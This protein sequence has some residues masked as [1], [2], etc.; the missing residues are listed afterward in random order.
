MISVCTTVNK[1][2][3]ESVAKSNFELFSKYW[4]NDIKLYVY[5]EDFEENNFS[6]VIFLKLFKESSDCLDFINRNKNRVFVPK[7]K[8]KPYKYDFLKFCYK[9]YTM[10]SHFRES[11][12]QYFIWLD[13]DIVSLN[14]IPIQEIYSIL[15]EEK[16]CWF[17]N[18]EKNKNNSNQRLKRHSETGFIIFNRYHPIAESFFNKFQ[19]IYDSDELFKLEEQNDS[20]IFDFVKSKYDLKFFEKMTDGTAENPL[21]QTFLKN[22]LYHPMGKLKNEKRHIPQ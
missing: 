10:C 6:N 22:V 9:S 8:L 18:R 3:Y 13:A 19:E 14:N 20:Y 11:K 7:T 12:E 21:D 16:F 15:N 17:L 1:E 4:P 2:Y 5:S